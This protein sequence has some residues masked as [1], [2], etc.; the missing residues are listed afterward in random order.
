M[1]LKDSGQARLWRESGPRVN[2]RRLFYRV[3]GGR[4][5][6]AVRRQV[7]LATRPLEMEPGSRDP[8]PARSFGS[9]I[10]G[11]E[12]PGEGGLSSYRLRLRLEVSLSSR[13][14]QLHE[15]ALLNCQSQAS[16]KAGFSGAT[17]CSTA[18][19]R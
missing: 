18:T 14:V 10:A 15:R 12:M 3:S 4:N 13:R 9:R 17:A 2:L 16:K 1:L 8:E 11:L 5:V 19:V 6:L 7:S